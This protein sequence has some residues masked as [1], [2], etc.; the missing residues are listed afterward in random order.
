MSQAQSKPQTTAG[1]NG[2]GPAPSVTQDLANRVVGWYADRFGRG[3]TQAKAYI[4]D[5]F[6]MIVLGGVQSQAERTL[7]EQGD[8]QAVFNL[9]RAI[10]E[11]NKGALCTLVAE[12]TGRPVRMMLSDHK[13]NEDTSV[14]VF[15]FE[16]ENLV[17]SRL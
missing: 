9:R 4:N 6:A 12:L 16:R 17:G 13:P 14:M 7:V 3:P 11:A 5:D 10:K 2:A 8:S 15:L 1:A